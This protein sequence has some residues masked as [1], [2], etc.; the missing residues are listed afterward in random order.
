MS[1]RNQ[2]INLQT[3]K[4]PGVGNTNL[5][6]INPRYNKTE[7]ETVLEGKNNTWI[8]FGRD[9]PSDTTS[10]FGGVGKD[11]CGS[12]DLVSGRISSMPKEYK[13]DES[14]VADNNIFLDASRVNIN[15][16]TNVDDN[17]FLAKGKVGNRVGKSAIVLK[18][19]NLRFISREGIKLVTGTDKYDSTGKL[20]NK[21][22]GIDLIAGN[23]DGDLQ[24]LVKGK[25][26]N[27]Y[28]KTMTKE[29]ASQGSELATI[30]KILIQ[31]CGF[32]AGHIHITPMG[33]SAPSIE[34]VATMPSV[35][36][37]AALHIMNL[38]T[39]Q[40]NLTMDKM[41]YLEPFGKK[42]LN[43]RYNNTN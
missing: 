40:I 5:S 34:L 31:I 4:I 27:E 25:N 26:L 14:L 6:E 15:Q 33:P 11:K 16:R 36:S 39:N 18:S 10:G 19:D 42:Y 23:K 17:Y 32:M 28:L 22:Y 21:T 38:Q 43:S 7:S 29:I 24:P 37:E 41:N 13:E 9:R 20:I 1:K 12:I 35:I 30:Y 3:S 8:V 2:S